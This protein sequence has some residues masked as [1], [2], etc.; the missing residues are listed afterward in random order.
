[1]KNLILRVIVLSSLVLFPFTLFHTAWNNRYLILPKE[2]IYIWG[3]SQTFFGF[4]DVLASK[5]LRREVRSF[6]HPASGVYD[7]YC[8]AKATPRKSIVIISYSKLCLVRRKSVDYN[9]SGLSA[10]GLF[11]LVRNNY[12]IEE[13]ITIFDLNKRP[14]LTFS[15]V[16]QVYPY[17]D[18]LVVASPLS[19]FT[20]YYNEL[21]PFLDDK[22]NVYMKALQLLKEKECEI[23]IVEYPVSMELMNIETSTPNRSSLEAAA[24]QISTILNIP[25]DTL[26][27]ETDSNYMYD[28]SHVNVVGRDYITKEL[29]SKIKSEE[30][31]R[32]IVFR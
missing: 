19:H 30:E 16:H 32:F 15:Q 7:F 1:M 20:S 22:K 4:D 17:S 25:V 24:N 23:T 2:S 21:I 3:D 18:S 13:A 6:A 12:S 5:L 10:P 9:R 26:W 31:S 28:F 29:V 8:F 14:D 11:T 27:L